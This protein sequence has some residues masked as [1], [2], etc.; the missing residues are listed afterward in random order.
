MDVAEV[1]RAMRFPMT[2][3]IRYRT[4]GSSDWN[5]GMTLNISRSG[6]LFTSEGEIS[7]GMVIEMW[8][9]LPPAFDSKQG[10]EL[11]STGIVVRGDD[12]AGAPQFAAHFH[13]YSLG[14]SFHWME[15]SAEKDNMDS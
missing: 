7:P 9:A 8:M 12:Q 13:H 11:V 2:A 15:I 6:V 5:A 10:A 3:P 14:R 1:P 4:V